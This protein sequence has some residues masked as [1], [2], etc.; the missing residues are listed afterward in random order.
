[1]NLDKQI[2]LASKSQRRIDL[3]KGL[4]IPFTTMPSSYEEPDF[5]TT[6]LSAAEYTVNNATEKARDVAR[7]VSGALVIGMDTIVEYNGN[8]Y[9]K[10]STRDEAEQMVKH[11]NA[12]THQVV[13]G[14]CLIDVDHEAEVSATEST[15]VT[16]EE[17]SQNEIQAYLDCCAWD[18]YAGGYAA[19]GLAS[20]FIKKIEGDFF[21]VVGLPIYRFG[22][23][24]K[25]I[26]MPV[27]DLLKQK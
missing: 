26:G 27:I 25:E 23:L 21:N 14:L 11:L 13:T 12:T 17:M 15:K 19:Q 8:L 7:N 22:H 18:Q 10:P 3:L 20:L 24:M 6:Q 16:F 4:N 9:G 1:M 5:R 2:I